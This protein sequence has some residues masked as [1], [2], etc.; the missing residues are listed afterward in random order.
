MA[1]RYAGAVERQVELLEA[2]INSWF[3]DLA[4]AFSLRD[5]AEVAR[6]YRRVA[7]LADRLE[8]IDKTAYSRI[9]SAAEAEQERLLAAPETELEPLPPLEAP[10]SGDGPAEG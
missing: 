2:D 6:I 9:L 7:A 1:D 4:D 8:E 3:T 10:D 5:W